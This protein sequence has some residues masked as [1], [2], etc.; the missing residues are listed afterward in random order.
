MLWADML[1]TSQP[2]TLQWCKLPNYAN[3]CSTGS[4]HCWL[5]MRKGLKSVCAV[6]NTIPQKVGAPPFVSLLIPFESL[7]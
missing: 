3:R 1:W 4:A 7:D 2:P 6:A 5:N